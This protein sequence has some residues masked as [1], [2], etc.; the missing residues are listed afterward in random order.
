MTTAAC[1][2]GVRDARY[3]PNL[4]ASVSKGM[5]RTAAIAAGIATAAVVAPVL[6]HAPATVYADVVSPV[7]SLQELDEQI[8]KIGTAE[9]LAQKASTGTLSEAEER[10]SLI[11]I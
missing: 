9:Q 10:L 2:E 8:R 3:R 4:N 11:H 1:N 7:R 5:F 6:T